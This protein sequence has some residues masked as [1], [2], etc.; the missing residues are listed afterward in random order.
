MNDGREEITQVEVGV[1][2][3][4]LAELRRA[5]EHEEEYPKERDLLSYVL[6]LGLELAELERRREDRDA[7]PDE[8]YQ[9]LADYQGAYA[10]LHHAFAEAA[11]DDQTGRMVNSA[12][13]RE[14]AATKEYLVPRLEREREQLGRRR[15]ALLGALGEDG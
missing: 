13:R 10:R 8:L 14:V 3:E 7:G 15:E 1:R 4:L 9:E 2:P 6:L 12:L 5:L 11:R